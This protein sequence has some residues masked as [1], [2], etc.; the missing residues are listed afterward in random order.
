MCPC[1]HEGLSDVG[2]DADIGPKMNDQGDS[3]VD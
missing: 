1:S 2:L 3:T